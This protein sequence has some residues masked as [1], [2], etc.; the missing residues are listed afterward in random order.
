MSVV[1]T[2]LHGSQVSL[3]GEFC[4]KDLDPMTSV[5]LCLENLISVHVSS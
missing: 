5:G 1:N 4:L 3:P 2:L